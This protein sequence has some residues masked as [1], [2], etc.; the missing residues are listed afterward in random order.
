MDPLQ[1]MPPRSFATRTFVDVSPLVARKYQWLVRFPSGLW[2][3]ADVRA[4]THGIDERPKL[5]ERSLPPPYDA[6]AA[7]IDPKRK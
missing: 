3:I 5:A 6:R 2:S 7:Q 1:Q 4:S